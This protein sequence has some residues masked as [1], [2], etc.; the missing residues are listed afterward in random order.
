MPTFV[1]IMIVAVSCA[2]VSLIFY[3]IAWK[4]VWAAPIQYGL[5]GIT[6]A[7]IWIFFCEIFFGWAV[8]FVAIGVGLG[9]GLFF[10]VLLTNPATND[11]VGD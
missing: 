11:L 5:V 9:I 4:L 8:P 3:G 6:C 10:T 7:G 1:L 2:L